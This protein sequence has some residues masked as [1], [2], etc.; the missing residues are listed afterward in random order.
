MTPPPPSHEPERTRSPELEPAVRAFRA[1]HPAYADPSVSPVVE[2]GSDAQMRD[3]L[4]ATILA[5]RKTLATT[6]EWDYEHESAALPSVGARE[7]LVD[8]RRRPVAALET[9]MVIVLPLGQVSEEIVVTPDGEYPTLDEW[10]EAHRDLWRS[11]DYRA[12]RGDPDYQVTDEDR[13]VIRRFIVA[14]RF[15]GER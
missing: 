5:G 1:E 6:L 3:A 11:P 4:V 2:F 15:D 9:T 10:R 8:S 13:V 12:Y 7:I 14:E